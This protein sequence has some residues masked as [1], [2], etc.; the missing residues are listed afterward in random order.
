VCSCD[1]FPHSGHWKDASVSCL[2][3]PHKVGAQLHE[4]GSGCK[5]DGYKDAAG[6]L[7]DKVFKDL[8]SSALCLLS[9]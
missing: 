4:V 3:S 1:R 6:N 9:D 2:N 8:L 7:N 5:G